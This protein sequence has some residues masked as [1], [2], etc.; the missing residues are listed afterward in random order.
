MQGTWSHGVVQKRCKGHFTALRCAVCF[1]REIG[2]NYMEMKDTVFIMM[3][4]RSRDGP[5]NI[6]IGVAFL[7]VFCNSIQ[8]PGCTKGN[9]FPS[10]GVVRLLCNNTFCRNCMVISLEVT[11]SYIACTIFEWI[12]IF[13]QSSTRSTCPLRLRLADSNGEPRWTSDSFLF[14]PT[15]QETCGQKHDKKTAIHFGRTWFVPPMHTASAISQH[16]NKSTHAPKSRHTLFL[17]NA[18]GFAAFVTDLQCFFREH[19]QAAQWLGF[20]MF[21]PNQHVESL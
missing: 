13:G 3:H 19:E 5:W 17:S 8:L 7:H 9:H 16:F 18:S 21:L 11:S 4:L 2:D 14:S 20:M 15:Y 6:R 12:R 1:F 10:I